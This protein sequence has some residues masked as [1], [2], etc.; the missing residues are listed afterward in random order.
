MGK[1]NSQYYILPLLFFLHLSCGVRKQSPI[2]NDFDFEGHRGCRGLYPENTIPAMLHAIDLGVTTLE[3]DICFTKDE[4][5]ILSH[6][7]FFNN[8]IT[9]LPNGDTLTAAAERS[10]LI[11]NMPYSEVKRYDVGMKFNSHFPRQQK[12]PVFK[13][14]LSDVI[15]SV[16]QYCKLHSKPIPYFNIET[17]TKPE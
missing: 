2:K 1:L 15:D 11:Y 6:D 8:E 13:P 14:L 17:K 3:M 12:I 16:V 5:P 4:L 10:L 9:T 7:P